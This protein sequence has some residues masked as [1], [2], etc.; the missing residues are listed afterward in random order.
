M[1][2]LIQIFF[3]D[4]ENGSWPY[5]TNFLPFL[6]SVLGLLICY[7][8]FKKYAIRENASTKRIKDALNLNV[9]S[10]VA[11]GLTFIVF[12]GSFD[13]PEALLPLICLSPFIYIF[14][15]IGLIMAF[16]RFPKSTQQDQK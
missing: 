12:A 8:V 7:L 2:S 13:G 3:V 15:I 9:I 10:T 16:S 14:P 4:R 5:W 11:V 6:G 1:V